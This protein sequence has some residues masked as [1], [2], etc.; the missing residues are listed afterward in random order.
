MSGCG[1][2]RLVNIGSVNARASRTSLVAHST[3]KAGLLGLTR[4]LAC[5]LGRLRAGLVRRE[6]AAA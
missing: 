5:E 2:G 6:A 1:W 4:S 3:A